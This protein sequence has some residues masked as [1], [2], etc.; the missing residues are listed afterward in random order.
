MALFKSTILA[1]ASGSVNGIV[2]SHNAGGT[3]MRNRSIPSN[4]G[5]DRQDQVRTAM[6]SISNAWKYVLTPAQRVLWRNFG[7]LTKVRNR[8]GDE[9][10]LSGIAAFN[11]VNLFRIST[12]GTTLLDE[13]P[14]VTITD[15]APSF[16]SLIA[17]EGVAPDV[18]VDIVIALAGGTPADYS[19]ACYISGAISPGVS[20]YRGP[21]PELQ[22]KSPAAATNTISTSLPNTTGAGQNIAARLTLYHTASGTPIW[23]VNT[24]ATTIAP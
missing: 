1:Q 8:L 4:P 7:A 21:Y 11:R 12:L 20:F 14:A 23:S 10:S 22:L 16:T 13:P 24:E 2:F 15:A 9:I 6:A 19:L 5:T 17:N 3:Y 18:T